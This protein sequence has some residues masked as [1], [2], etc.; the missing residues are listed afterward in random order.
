MHMFQLNLL[1]PCGSDFH[2]LSV[3]FPYEIF[4]YKNLLYINSHRNSHI[5]SRV[6]PVQAFYEVSTLWG[7]SLYCVKVE[8]PL[9]PLFRLTCI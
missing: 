6:M 7:G 8:I 3:P 9:P 2:H 4:D 5:Y 1:I